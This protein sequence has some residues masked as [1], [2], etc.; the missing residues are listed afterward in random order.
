MSS[1]SNPPPRRH[2]V[3]AILA[4]VLIYA[5][6]AGLWI[7]LSDRLLDWLVSDPV[8]LSLISTL[9][10]WLFVAVTSL[11]L[12]ALMRRLLSFERGGESTLF[13]PSPRPL[14]LPL[15]LLATAIAILTLG[16]IA[17]DFSHQ[18]DSETARLKTIAE[19]KTRQIAN[20]LEERLDD[21]WFLRY[22]R[23]SGELDSSQ[24]AAGESVVSA[25]LSS[26]LKTFMRYNAFHGVML[27]NARGEPVWNLDGSTP[28]PDTRLVAAARQSVTDQTVSHYGPYRDDHG[29]IHLDFLVPLPGRDGQPGSVIVLHTDP[30]ADFHPILQSWPLP[31]TTGETLLVR[32]EGEQVALL[33]KLRDLP[34]AAMTLHFPLA[35]PLLRD[36][37]KLGTLLEGVDDR[38]EP[39]LGVALAIP[40]TDWFLL[41]KLDRA[42]LY[43]N[44]A[45]DA[46]WIGLAGLL[47]LFMTATGAFL[48]RQR[49]QLALAESL[50]CSQ[51]E[52]LEA[53]SRLADETARRHALI[54][55][56]RDGIVVFDDNHQVLES[57]QRFAEMLGYPMEEMIGL[58]CWDIDALM[59]EMQ[60]CERFPLFPP[61]G[62]IF[63]TRHRRRD[64][65]EYDVEISASATHW[66]GR[67]LV[68][69]I[70]RDISERKHTEEQ[71]NQY[72]HHLEELVEERT[73]ALHRQSHWLRAIIDNI[74]HIIWLKDCEGRFLAVNR[75]LAEITGYGINDLLGKTDFDLWP[76]ELSERYRADDLAVMTTR[77]QKMVEEEVPNRPDIVYETFKAPVL[78]VDGDVLGTVGFSRDIS[79]QKELERVR[80][81][82]RQAA[83]SANR[84]KSA[85]LANMSHEIRTPMNAIVGLTYLLQ[86]SGLTPEQAARLGKIESATQHLLCIVNDVLDFSKIEAGRLELEQT[87]FSLTSILDHACALVAEQAQSKGLRIQIQPD[88]VPPWLFGDP[89]RLRQ[90]LLNFLG[91]AVKFTERGEIIVRTSLLESSDDRLLIRFEVVDT[92]IGIAPDELTQLFTPFGQADV[93]TTRKHGGTGLGLAITRRL[94]QLMGGDAGVES[95]PGQG[96]TFW[97]TA[98]LNRGHDRVHPASAPSGIESELRR[99]GAGFRLLLAE[100]NPINRDVALDLLHAVGMVV[101]TAEN[102]RDAVVMAQTRAYD[103]VLM[104]VQ[105]PDMDGLE[106]TRQ[107]RA[108]N[109]SAQI[110]ILAM[111]ANAFEEDRQN[112]LQAGMNDFVAKPVEPDALYSTLLKWLPS[113]IRQI[114]GHLTHP[115]VTDDPSAPQ[116]LSGLPGLDSQRGLAA[117]R[118]QRTIYLRLLRLFTQSHADDLSTLR[119]RLRDGDELGAVR[120]VHGLKGAALTLGADQLAQHAAHLEVALERRSGADFIDAAVNALQIELAQL[121][122]A[123]MALPEEDEW[124][125]PEVS[126]QG[127]ILSQ[128]L[129]ELERLLLEDNVQS[130]QFM[131]DSGAILRTG[132]GD[133]FNEI[134]R[135]TEHFNFDAALLRLKAAM[136]QRDPDQDDT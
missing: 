46:I 9:K 71:L 80:D 64:G 63:E 74:P 12:Y 25:D 133:A 99:C 92:G 129:H 87:D 7:L 104:D 3:S 95:Q 131:R 83:E 66:G 2:L 39:V 91:N 57:N 134:L 14:L 103:L 22:S 59:S 132:L 44:V 96:S 108:Q 21:A 10:G 72:R 62:L 114:S 20:W 76:R 29:A 94:A 109:Q 50:H 56:S 6:F 81:L 101:E 47:A 111:T 113:S 23:L 77:Q 38:G 75:A 102:G 105:M 69:C 93:S 122:A 78:D 85:F 97:F 19:F 37:S 135:E 100:D 11:I 65:S 84:A 58:R 52:R 43:A 48:L 128:L 4:I 28:T 82:A 31:T 130:V 8:L 127:I 53:L 89:T 120:V 115:A 27:L 110:P 60:I 112:C 98:R 79:A 34:G 117:V 51:I 86:R 1:D 121:V 18:K 55:I 24:F 73:A 125:T 17:I 67:N 33:G 41:A 90:S 61:S 88:D 49:Q 116:W 42:E 118:G 54:D 45:N 68:L 32:R 136:Q 123:I 13:K 124:M 36:R 15:I 5:V 70:C 26:Y 119:E 16:G 106:A 107:I 35:T 40:E 126:A 30:V